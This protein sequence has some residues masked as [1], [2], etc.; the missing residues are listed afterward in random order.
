MKLPQEN[1]I[2]AACNRFPALDDNGKK[3]LDAYESLPWTF[4]TTIFSRYI[5]DSQTASVEKRKDIAAFLEELVEA[6]NFFYE[7]IKIDL[8]HDFL[9]S[10]AMIDAYYLL[11]GPK[12]RHLVWWLAPEFAPQIVIPD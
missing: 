5:H 1:C 4:L 10:Q 9:K 11:L 2:E 3:K 6:D 8:V 12:V 7:V